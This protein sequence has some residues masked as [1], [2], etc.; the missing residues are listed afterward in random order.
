[1]HMTAIITDIVLP[2]SLVGVVIGGTD[3]DVVVGTVVGNNV[4]FIT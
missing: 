2:G 1:M 3:V 4:F